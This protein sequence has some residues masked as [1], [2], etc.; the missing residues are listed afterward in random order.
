MVC[1]DCKIEMTQTTS[2]I[3]EYD[4]RFECPNGCGV[5][6]VRKV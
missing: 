5:V 2:G 4:E 6:Y 1:G 3:G